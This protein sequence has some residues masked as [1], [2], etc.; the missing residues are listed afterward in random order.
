MKYI[1]ITLLGLLFI[2]AVGLYLQEKSEAIEF[3]VA[4]S[5][6]TPELP[7]PSDIQAWLNELE[8]EPRLEV[9]GIIGPKTIVKW[10]RVYT[11][12]QARLLYDVDAIM[13]NEK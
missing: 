7:S 1:P 12:R 2:A 11:R 5:P 10:E 13:E 6:D 3:Q 4:A 9:D 8:P